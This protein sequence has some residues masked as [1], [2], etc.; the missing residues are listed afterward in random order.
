MNGARM[1]DEAVEAATGRSWAAWRKVLDRMGAAELPHKEIVARLA[2]E[3]GASPWWRQMITVEYERMIG[4]RVVGQRCDGAYTAGASRTVALAQDAAFAAWTKLAKR[5]A[6]CDGVK[7]DGPPRVTKSEKW[8]YWRASL[9]DGSR[10]TISV[11]AKDGGKSVVT[12][13]QEGVTTKAAAARWKLYW[14]ERLAELPWDAE[15]RSR[16]PRAHRIS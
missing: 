7:I 2:K 11:A 16:A 5:H 1:S 4:R 9:A 12:V 3:Q 8:R 10:V 6:T 14:R 13:D 15:F